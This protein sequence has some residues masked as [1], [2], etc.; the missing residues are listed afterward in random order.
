M[1]RT[2]HLKMLS[3]AWSPRLKYDDTR[4]PFMFASIDEVWFPTFLD[5]D[6]TDEYID[7][8]YLFVLN[9][10]IPIDKVKTKI[11]NIA[12]SLQK[13][14]RLQKNSEY[15]KL[16]LELINAKLYWYSIYQYLCETEG[17]SLEEINN[18]FSM[19]TA[20]KLDDPY[21]HLLDKFIEVT[22]R[23]CDIDINVQTGQLTKNKN[24][25]K[26]IKNVSMRTNTNANTNA[27]GTRE[28]TNAMGTREN[29][30]AMGTE[31]NKIAK[32]KK[33]NTI[34]KSKSKSIT[35]AMTEQ[36]EDPNPFAG[37]QTEAT[38]ERQGGRRY[39]RRPANKNKAGKRGF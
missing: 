6:L 8:D 18:L 32:N 29:T 26:L 16:F 24:V 13:I 11:Y 34:A 9:T 28:N 22:Y 4:K 17:F 20:P 5:D 39:V 27:M 1:F 15:I 25:F 37:A 23:I 35:I 33:S 3:V 36:K 10:K 31:E 38:A 2:Y 30:N 7:E 12:S 19:H 14:K 21:K